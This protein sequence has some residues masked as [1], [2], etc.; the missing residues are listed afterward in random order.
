MHRIR[1]LPVRSAA[2]FFF[3][4][5]TLVRIAVK[6]D[7]RATLED[8]ANIDLKRM[9]D[10]GGYRPESQLERDSRTRIHALRR[11]L[12]HAALLVSGSALVALG[13]GLLIKISSAAHIQH[14]VPRSNLLVVA[15][16]CL[17]RCGSSIRGSGQLVVSRLWRGRTAGRFKRSRCSGRVSRQCL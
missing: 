17:Q 6:E 1:L 9:Y 3:A 12:T 2:A 14:S 16:Y 15:R 7:I 4:P 8:P 10:E 5:E 13:V 11:S